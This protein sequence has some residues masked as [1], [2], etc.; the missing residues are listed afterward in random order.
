MK[1]NTNNTEKTQQ[2]EDTPRNKAELKS[3]SNKSDRVFIYAPSD[4]DVTDDGVV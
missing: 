3:L 4:V 1:D 2:I